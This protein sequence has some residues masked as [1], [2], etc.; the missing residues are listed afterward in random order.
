MSIFVTHYDGSTHFLE[1][2]DETVVEVFS[3]QQD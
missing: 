2:Q 3:K 1:N